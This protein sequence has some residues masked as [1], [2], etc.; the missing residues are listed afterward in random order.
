MCKNAP[1]GA[2]LY[3]T[4]R[5]M[6]NRGMR[7]NQRYFQF[8]KF[9]PRT[10]QQRV[11]LA[12]GAAA[13]MFSLFIITIF[14]VSGLQSFMIRSDSYASVISAVL[15]DLAN[16]DR[17]SNNIGGLTVD[18]LL[19]EAA[20]AKANDMASKGYF[21]HISPQG[22]DSWYWF[23]EVGYNFEYAGE[24][25]AV[26][27]SDSTDVNNAWLNSPSH[28]EN[29][30]NGH[31][32]QIG[33]ATAAGY[34]QGHPTVFVVQMFGSP[35]PKSAPPVAV[36]QTI[37]KKATEIAVASA[38]VPEK[39]LGAETQLPVVAKPTVPTI[40]VRP[41]LPVPQYAPTWGYGLTSPKTVLKYAY[42]GLAL[43]LMLALW[44][45]TRFE[46]RIHHVQHYAMASAMVALMLG[47]FFV[48]D[49]YV[50]GQPTIAETQ[51]Q[52]QA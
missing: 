21:A 39:V 31:F 9:I 12:G 24:N 2:F 43:A 35:A 33:I 49:A 6:A 38:Q 47:L 48:A 37:P 40:T 32:T 5:G 50:L 28:R 27:F 44:F 34:Y 26:D 29:I 4:I 51:T 10:K 7:H 42:F 13:G 11:E 52:L 20:Q 16:G 46:M 36:T 1:L 23:K 25:L 14:V 30:M 3:E 19:T 15:V 41:S 22:L 18:P 45:I 8:R 17:A